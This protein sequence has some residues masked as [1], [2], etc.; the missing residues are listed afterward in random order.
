MKKRIWHR[1]LIGV[2]I[3]GT[4]T[5]TA[6]ADTLTLEQELQF[7]YYFHEVQRLYNLQQFQQAQ[8]IVEFCYYLNPNDATINNYMA[9]FARSI[10]QPEKAKYHF[11]KA[12]ELDPTHY[13]NNYN[14]TLL[15]EGTRQEK[16]QALDNLEKV[17]RLITKDEELLFT[18]SR[19]YLIEGYYQKAI[20]TLNR[21]D[22]VVGINENTTHMRFRIYM[23]LNDTTHAIQEVERYVQYDPYNYQF[24]V[25]RMQLYQE[26]QQP[27]D[28]CI[29]AYR[30]VLQLE[31][32]NLLALNNL[33]WLLCT[34]G[35]D[36]V[37][38]EELSRTTLMQEAQNPIYLDTYAWICYLL[39]DCQ[40]ARYFIQKAIENITPETKED[41]QKHY[42]EI[43]RKCKK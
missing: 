13:W 31:P 42:K 23:V 38:A 4:R 41:I 37:E 10:N 1:I 33:A 24:Q 3:L 32:D 11:Q 8:P 30:G 18:L 16:Q 25:L 6:H 39:G 9:Y 27:A 19:A 26:T 5:A 29:T 43:K 12:F 34:Q 7:K 17:S 22:S 28:K 40:A 15:N 20:H 21:L 14:I 35:G 36:L 2:L